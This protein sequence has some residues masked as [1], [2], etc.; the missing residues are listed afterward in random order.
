MATPIDP[1]SLAARHLTITL[2]G[3]LVNYASFWTETLQ[4]DAVDCII[5][6]FVAHRSSS[7]LLSYKAEDAANAFADIDRLKAD[8][9]SVAA[10]NIYLSLGMSRETVRR[11]LTD[12]ERKGYIFKND[13]GYIFP[14]QTGALDYT[15]PMRK[16]SL[17]MAARVSKIFNEHIV[18]QAKT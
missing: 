5:L 3:E 4:I 17:E 12:L 11:R 9:I 13:S 8:R 7:H 10:K 18:A 1:D 2:I 16:Y 15:L 14:V 6:A